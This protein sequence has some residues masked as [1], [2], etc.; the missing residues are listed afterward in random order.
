MSPSPGPSPRPARGRG[1]RPAAAAPNPLRQ[2]RASDLRGVARL[3][4]QATTH[5]TRVA[6]G[7][8]QSVLGTLGLPADRDDG[9][10]REE[11][12]G[13]HFQKWMSRHAKRAEKK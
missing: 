9:R 12:M 13:N 11:D 2:L 4:T 3:A 8:H 1:P 5:I 6:E 10:G 7:V